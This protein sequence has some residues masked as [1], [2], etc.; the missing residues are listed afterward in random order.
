M[1]KGIFTDSDLLYRID[2]VNSIDFYAMGFDVMRGETYARNALQWPPQERTDV[3]V[4][5]V[6]LEDMSG[7]ELAERIRRQ[8][9]QVKVIF[10]ADSPDGA[11]AQAAVRF[12]AFDYLLKSAGVDAL[13]RV[14]ERAIGQLN[15]ERR[16]SAYIHA[17]SDWD[18]VIPQLLRLLSALKQE[19]DADHWRAYSGVRPLLNGSIFSAEALF[20]QALM[21]ELRWQ[22]RCRDESL[23]SQIRSSMMNS[24]LDTLTSAQGTA[25]CIETIW[26]LLSEKGYISQ[27][28]ALKSDT[29]GRACVYMHAHLGE[30]LTAQSVAAY[31]HISSRHFVRKFRAEMNETFADYLLRIRIKA[32]IGMLKNGKDIK[33]IPEA[34][35]YKDKKSFC[36]AFKDY[37]GCSMREYQQRLNLSQRKE[38]EP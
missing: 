11:D 20:A 23:V 33:S 28:D 22:I 8:M 27:E 1:Y 32:A 7:F 31:A 3:L 6:R 26:T 9:P 4:T 10:L 14:I 29:I 12:G 36:A 18:E 16:E 30:K 2:V 35:G 15:A 13:R 21:E 19:Q 37:T 38:K 24:S 34:V 17:Q 5:N 25:A